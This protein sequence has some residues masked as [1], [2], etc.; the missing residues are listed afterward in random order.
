MA[1]IFYQFIAKFSS[2]A[3]RSSLE[4]SS[5][6]LEKLIFGPKQTLLQWKEVY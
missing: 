1:K 2:K 5:K 4:I 6:E 3:S